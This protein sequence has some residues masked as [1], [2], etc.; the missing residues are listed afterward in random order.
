[1]AG[2]QIVVRNFSAEFHE[3]PTRGLVAETRSRKGGHR[4]GRTEEREL[5]IRQPFF[6]T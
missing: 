3:N 1:M 6:T 5:H 4:D 2:Q